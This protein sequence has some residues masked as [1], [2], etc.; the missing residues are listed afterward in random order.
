MQGFGAALHALSIL[1]SVGVTSIG[2][3][4]GGGIAAKGAINALNIAPKSGPEILR[5]VII[6]LA[7]IETGG[8]LGVVMGLILLFGQSMED[9]SLLYIG[10]SECGIAFALGITGCIVGA[11]SAL[12]A[13][14]AAHS[15]AR[16]PFFSAKI[17]N[18]MLLTQSIIQTPVIFGFLISLFIKAQLVQVHDLTHSIKLLSSGLALGLAC[19]GPILGLARFARIAVESVGRNRDSYGKVMTFT[20]ISQA[21][22]ETPIIFAFV[23]AIIL[24]VSPISTYDS[25]LYGIGSIAAALAIGIGTLGPGISS[26]NIAGAACRE[27]AIDPKNSSLLMKTSILGQSI[28]EA[29]AIY[30]LLI[31]LLLLLL[32]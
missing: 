1:F 19:I 22:I 30:A 14:Q 12:P 2:V 10:I 25:A 28:V 23:I 17:I 20:F 18:T 15:I 5:A 27:I 4:L 9:P 6:G 21:I 13:R 16:Q 31:S 8:I 24:L 7:L 11:Y 3:G 29:A 32:K 26:G